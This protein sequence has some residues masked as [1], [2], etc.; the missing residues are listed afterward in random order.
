MSNPFLV[1]QPGTKSD[2]K[3]PFDGGQ[4]KPQ[5]DSIQL[6]H[7]GEI[8]P[9]NPREFQMRSWQIIAPIILIVKSLQKKDD[10]VGLLCR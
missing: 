8:A 5:I 1:L 4:V 10:D 9:R 6:K 3:R 2:R 7:N